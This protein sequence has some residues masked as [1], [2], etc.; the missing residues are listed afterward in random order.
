MA[1]RGTAAVLLFAEAEGRRAA[2]RGADPSVL[3]LRLRHLPQQAPRLPPQ[4]VAPRWSARM[5]ASAALPWPPAD[6]TACAACSSPE[7]G[8]AVC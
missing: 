8:L 5:I 7:P 4:E 1:A 6:S 2:P 3:E